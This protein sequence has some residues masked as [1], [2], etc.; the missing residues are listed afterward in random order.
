MQTVMDMK[1]CSSVNRAGTWG[2]SLRVRAFL[3]YLSLIYLQSIFPE[4][5]AAVPN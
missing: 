5:T 1:I 4:T 3:K 2:P